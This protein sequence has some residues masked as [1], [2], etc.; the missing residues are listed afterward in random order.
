MSVAGTSVSS[1]AFAGI[2]AIINQK[3]MN[4][5]P[6]NVAGDGR[7]G[8]ANYVLYPLAAAES[9]SGFGPCDS[10]NQINPAMRTTCAFNDITAGNNSVP[11]VTGFDAGT[12]F[13]LA[14]GLGSVDANN[15][16]TQWSAAAGMFQGTSNTLSTTAATPISIT[17]G[18]SVPFTVSVAR[19][20]AA[21]TPS[22]DVSLI[23]QGGSLSSAVELGFV[24]IS[25]SSG[26]ATANFSVSNLPGGTNYTISAFYPGDGTFAGGTSGSITVTVNP[27]TPTVS[28]TVPARIA[29]GVAFTASAQVNTRVG[30]VPATGTLQFFDGTTA[31]G[32][33]LTVRNNQASMQAT[34]TH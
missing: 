16:A 28:V 33:P 26:T 34:I 3:V 7:Q 17:H 18:D 11:N 13:D 23:A 14:S 1:P 30:S 25:G 24:S 31:L 6:S 21:G 15:L 10:S 2:M 22:G 5:H 32:L 12:G 9:A 27:E 4:E 20:G 19:A 8:L 29:T